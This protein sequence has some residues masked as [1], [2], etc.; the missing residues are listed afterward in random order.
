MLW[1]G[2]RQE[3]WVPASS[4]WRAG[5][6]WGREGAWRGSQELAAQA[7]SGTALGRSAG[8]WDQRAGPAGIP[9][10]SCGVSVRRGGD[11]DFA[12]AEPG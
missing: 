5:V 11:G 2:R 12:G 3:G 4:G 10:W 9:G 8:T 7:Q 1:D 6:Q